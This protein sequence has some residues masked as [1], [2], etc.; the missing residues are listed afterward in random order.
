MTGNRAKSSVVWP[1]T[2]LR[3][4]YKSFKLK[5][6]S[7]KN[8]VRHVLRCFGA[9]ALKEKKKL[10]V[11]KK[12]CETYKTFQPDESETGRCDKT[13]EQD[14]EAKE[15]EVFRRCKNTWLSRGLISPERFCSPCVWTAGGPLQM[16]CIP[17]PR[18]VTNMQRCRAQSDI[19]GKWEPGGKVIKISGRHPRGQTSA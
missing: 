9:V 18:L 11:H 7:S 1:H 14:Q 2:W 19:G 16:L 4:F 10:G 6:S 17:L 8:I 12:S 3:N 5:F 15:V 13:E